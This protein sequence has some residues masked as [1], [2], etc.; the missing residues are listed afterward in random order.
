[1]STFPKPERLN[2]A[3]LVTELRAAGI[4]VDDDGVRDEADG[5][6]TVVTD[7]PEAEV[8]AVI[9][10]HVPPPPPADPDD[11]FRD[12]VTAAIA[13]EPAGSPLRKLADALLGTSGPGAE[14]RRPTR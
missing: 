10:A 6:I 11:E 7:A 8:Q 13:D 4:D 1:M 9:D 3:A 14:P 5:T 2:G 12:A